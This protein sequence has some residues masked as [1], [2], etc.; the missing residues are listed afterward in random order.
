MKRRPGFMEHW[1]ANLGRMRA[2]INHQNS[3]KANSNLRAFCE[4]RVTA[5]QQN[6]AGRSELRA[7]PEFRGLNDFR[8]GFFADRFIS[9]ER[10][11]QHS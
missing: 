6:L 7:G 10:V 2:A 4:L 8:S 11:F 5:V 9:V 1:D 3:R